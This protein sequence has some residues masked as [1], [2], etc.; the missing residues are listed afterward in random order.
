M[1][2]ILADIGLVAL[3][4]D[5]TF[6]DGMLYYDAAG[7]VLKAFSAHDG[8]GLNLLGRAGITWGFITGRHDA[9]T[10]AR[11]TYLGAD[12]YHS[13]VGDKGPVLV[14]ICREYGIDPARSVFMG[15]DLNDLTA[16][17]AAGVSV[18]P[19]NA[20]TPV[21]LRVDLVL[22]REG[23]RGAVRELCDRIIRAKGLDPVELWLKDKSTPVGQ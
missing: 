17:E 22:E 2:D 8:M 19:A 3:D 16:F 5:G 18:A 23:G 13:K 6:T 14:E 15:D 10:E 20:V 12:F 1:A 9:A 21:K 11:V 4:V 7:Q